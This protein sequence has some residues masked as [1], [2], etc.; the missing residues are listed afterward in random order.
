M[1]NRKKSKMYHRISRT[2]LVFSP[3]SERFAFA[4][5][6][7]NYYFAVI[8]GKEGRGYASVPA[9]PMFSPDSRRTAYIAVKEGGRHTGVVDGVEGTPFVWIHPGTL[10]FSPDSKHIAYWAQGKK[11]LHY[12]MV[13]DHVPTRE[14]AFP[15]SD[16]CHGLPRSMPVWIA[17]PRPMLRWDG[18]YQVIGAVIVGTEICRVEVA[19]VPN[20]NSPRSRYR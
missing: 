17:C 5:A 20:A 1:I 18:P 2:S 6:R 3:N 4:A 8:D 12:T 19:I 7:S 9:G 10:T 15:I 14:Y 11:T 13:I 16:G